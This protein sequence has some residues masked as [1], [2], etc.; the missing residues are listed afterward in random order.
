MDYQKRGVLLEVKDDGNGFKMDGL[1]GPDQGHFGL[2]GMRERSAAI[3]SK[4]EVQSTTSGTLVRVK[5]QL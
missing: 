4:F 2:T 5:V 3:N 1:P